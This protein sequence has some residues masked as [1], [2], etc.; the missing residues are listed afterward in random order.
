MAE[1]AAVRFI[2]SFADS[3]HVR[4]DVLGIVFRSH[5][6]FTTVESGLAADLRHARISDPTVGSMN[7]AR[8]GATQRRT[9]PGGSLWQNHCKT[10]RRRTLG[11]RVIYRRQ[12]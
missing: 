9:E 12:D 8:D 1:L 7:K 3:A 4:S 10:S 6:T 5:N 11:D 2:C